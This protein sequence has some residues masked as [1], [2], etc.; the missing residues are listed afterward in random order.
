L[1]KTRRRSKGSAVGR[2]AETDLELFFRSEVARFIVPRETPATRRVSPGPKT[3]LG[4]REQIG[5]GLTALDRAG[6]PI[7][8]TDDVMPAEAVIWTWPHLWG[9]WIPAFAGMTL[10]EGKSRGDAR[11][12]ELTRPRASWTLSFRATA[13]S[14][15]HC[16]GYHSPRIRVLAALRTGHARLRTSAG[17][18][19]TQRGVLA[20]RPYYVASVGAIPHFHAQSPL[21][22]RGGKVI[23][24]MADEAN[25]WN[26]LAASFPIKRI[27]HQKPTAK[28]ALVR[29]A[30]GGFSAGGAIFE[31]ALPGV[32]ITLS[33]DIGR[34]GLLERGNAA[35]M[36]AC[37]RD[38]AK[39]VMAGS[40]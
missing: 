27:N 6:R 20:Y 17:Q 10:A 21:K 12:I 37:L 15:G 2:G 7:S 14:D 13:R 35:V 18:R 23:E 9:L 8:S 28:T 30:R 31:K 33:T 3:N 29:M 24:L 4:L 38:L 11:G 26:S 40:S 34:I 39:L 25:S 1:S 22:D 19:R 5:Q 36:N 32:H 16:E